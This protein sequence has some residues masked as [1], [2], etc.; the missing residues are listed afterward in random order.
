V[1]SRVSKYLETPATREAESEAAARQG[2]HICNL[3]APSTS[4]V[5]VC[6]PCA[7]AGGAMLPWTK[8]FPFPAITLIALAPSP[9]PPR[10]RPR[11]GHVF[12]FLAMKSSQSSCSWAAM[13]V[14]RHWIQKILCCMIIIC[15]MLYD[16]V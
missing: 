7:Q 5:H 9:S 8:P 15:M 10:P 6:T 1:R 13:R 14:R 11:L 2:R 12:I 4:R 16:V 3:F